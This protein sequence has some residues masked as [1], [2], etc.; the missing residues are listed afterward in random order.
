MSR[1]KVSFSQQTSVYKVPRISPSD[2]PQLYYQKR[3]ILQFKQEVR[4][5]KFI[6]QYYGAGLIDLLSWFGMI[7]QDGTSVSCI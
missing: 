1:K 2:V 5:E 6:C 7:L 4:R 3:E